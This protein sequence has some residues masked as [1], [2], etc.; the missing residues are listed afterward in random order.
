MG[1]PQN[2]TN[3]MIYEAPNGVFYQYSS[4]TNSW[5]RINRPNIPLATPYRDGLMSSDDFVKLTGLMIPPPEINL[6][7]EGCD[8]EYDRGFLK[9]TG[10]REGIVEVDISEDKLHENTSVIN[11]G[12]NVDNLVRKLKDLG[13]LRLISPQG[14]PGDRGEPGEDGANALPV[15]PPGKDGRD[16][17]NAAWPGTISEETFDV[18]Q[19]NRAIVD[20]ETL[21]ISPEENYIVVKR[22]NIGNVDACPD[23]VIPQ[24][25]QS[26]WVLSYATEPGEQVFTELVSPVTG[27]VCGWA[28]NSE[29]FYFDIDNVIQAV[30]SQTVHYLNKKREEKEEIARIWLAAMQNEFND[31]KS[32]L[33]CAL[34]ACRSRSRNEQTRQY[35]ESQ[36][37]QA[38]MGDFRLIIGGEDD[39]HFPPL[40]DEGECEWNIA[41][42]NYNLLRITDPECTIDWPSL[43][44]G[45]LS[46]NGNG[47][48]DVAP[49]LA[50]DLVDTFPAPDVAIEVNPQG[51][52][53][54]VSGTY[55]GRVYEGD[56]F[57]QWTWEGKHGWKLVIW[58]C[59]ADGKF[60]ARLFDSTHMFGAY[61]NVTSCFQAGSVINIQ[62]VSPGEKFYLDGTGD[63]N[64]HRAVIHIL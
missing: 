33:C 31:Q 40:N 11:L 61:E 34:E 25:T 26:P 30:H 21:N 6:K 22:A 10:D 60:G 29:L 53:S 24:D 3:K 49:S 46:G 35:I 17:R 23:S 58:Y 55:S 57:S 38:A 52:F 41:P 16:G 14:P 28:C 27:E 42:A 36:R 7:F 5:S 8:V 45:Q 1:F 64:Q 18:A 9:I 19:Q 50:V 2:P 56:E 4:F 37:I 54:S 13:N 62:E 12:L 63:A 59:K 39:K 15:G 48:E 43:C 44:P 47:A 20:I 32:A 51:M